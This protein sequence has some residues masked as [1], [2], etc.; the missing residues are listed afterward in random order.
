[1]HVLPVFFFPDHLVTMPFRNMRLQV[2]PVRSIAHV[3]AD[4]IARNDAHLIQAHK[5]PESRDGTP[6]ETSPIVRN[7]SDGRGR[8]VS[9]LQ[10]CRGSRDG[11]LPGFDA[12]G[13]E[14]EG[15]FAGTLPAMVLILHLRAPRNGACSRD[16]CRP[17][18]RYER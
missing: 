14:I 12:K 3:E 2:V 13:F 10:C 9:Y 18:V 6:W 17:E 5:A 4:H 15:L 16:G 8:L 1:M 7:T 11:C